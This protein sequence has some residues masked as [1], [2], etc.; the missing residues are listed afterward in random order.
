M[1]HYRNGLC[2]AVVVACLGTTVASAQ[3]TT[4][5]RPPTAQTQSPPNGAAPLDSVPEK[6]KPSAAPAT[7][8][9]QNTSDALAK[10]GGVIA[11]KPGVDPEMR[12]PPAPTNDPMTVPPPPPQT[13]KDQHPN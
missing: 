6:I 7:T 8:P 5:P 3:T 4:E 2:V 1:E 12:V 10:T 9:G 13:S 11:P